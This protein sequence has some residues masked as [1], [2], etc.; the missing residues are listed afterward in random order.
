MLLWESMCKLNTNEIKSG[1]KKKV[2]NIVNKR[3]DQTSS[4]FTAKKI[5]IY[6]DS[7]K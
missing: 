2:S 4:Q 6:Y 3:F 5:L 1:K 7:R